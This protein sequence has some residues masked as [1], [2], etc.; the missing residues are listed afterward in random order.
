MVV[1]MV[2]MLIMPVGMYRFNS[3]LIPSN[4]DFISIKILVFF[5]FRFVSANSDLYSAYLYKLVQNFNT[6]NLIF[7]I[8]LS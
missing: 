8:F 2:S 6:L 1:G 5:V 7:K 3:P 4:I